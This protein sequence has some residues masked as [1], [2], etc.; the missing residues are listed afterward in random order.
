M[1]KPVTYDALRTEIQ[2]LYSRE[3]GLTYFDEDVRFGGWEAAS[4]FRVCV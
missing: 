3:L 2:G 4:L 1:Q